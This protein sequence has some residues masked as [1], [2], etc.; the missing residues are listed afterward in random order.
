M[1][2]LLCGKILRETRRQFRE[3][4]GGRQSRLKKNIV[5]NFIYNVQLNS[6]GKLSDE[7]I[8]AEV[9]TDKN[10]NSADAVLQP[11]AYSE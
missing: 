4:I 1:Q 6:F 5:L 10:V 7:S 2:V 8:E 11:S 3:G 9:E